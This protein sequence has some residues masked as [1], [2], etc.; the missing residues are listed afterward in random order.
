MGFSNHDELSR[1]EAALRSDRPRLGGDVESAICGRLGGAR[2]GGGR[3]AS[4]AVVLTVGTLVGMSAFGG[5]GYA[6]HGFFGFNPFNP[7]QHDKSPFKDEY[8]KPGKGP[9]HQKNDN[10]N[11]GKHNGRH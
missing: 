2:A 4:L 5:V 1:I 7:T 11:N 3:R 9:K 10:G 8:G 6:N